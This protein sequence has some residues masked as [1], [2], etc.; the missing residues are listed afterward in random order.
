MQL[1]CSVGDRG[2]EDAG[3]ASEVERL[4][5]QLAAVMESRAAEINED[6]I[7]LINQLSEVRLPCLHPTVACVL[8][9]MLQGGPAVAM[10][11]PY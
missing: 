2:A 9:W 6:N 10:S 8:G 1:R 4:K 3:Q 11:G 7:R 5:R